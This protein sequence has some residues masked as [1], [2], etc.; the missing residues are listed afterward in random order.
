MKLKG[1]LS[2][3]LFIATL[4]LLPIFIFW[5]RGKLISGVHGFWAF[6]FPIVTLLVFLPLLIGWYAWL[7]EQRYVSKRVEVSLLFFLG[8]L[9][10]TISGLISL[11]GTLDLHLHDTWYIISW[12]QVIILVCVVLVPFS[13]VYFFFPLVFGR[14][15]NILLSRFHFWVTYLCLCFLLGLSSSGLLTGEP[16][17]FMVTDDYPIIRFEHSGITIAL[18]FLLTAQLVF[19]IN[20]ALSFFSASKSESDN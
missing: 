15:L 12:M 20:V 14:D 16:R 1:L 6:I 3:G 9:C 10:L 2:I 7:K 4:T 8:I 5:S 13:I 18:V 11:R 19:I 17:R